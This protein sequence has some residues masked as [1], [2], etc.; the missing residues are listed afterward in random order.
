M[1]DKVWRMTM[2]QFCSVGPTLWDRVSQALPILAKRWQAKKRR[3]KTNPWRQLRESPSYITS[4]PQIKPDP[5]IW[6]V[7]SC[8]WCQ[9]LEPCSSACLH[10]NQVVERTHRRRRWWS[11]YCWRHAYFWPRRQRWCW[12]HCPPSLPS[13]CCLPP[14]PCQAETLSIWTGRKEYFRTLLMIKK[15]QSKGKM[16]QVLHSPGDHGRCRI[17]IGQAQEHGICTANVPIIVIPFYG[18]RRGV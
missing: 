6:R 1:R 5:S 17:G 9:V 12:Q 18:Y 3:I 15:W 10:V 8:V 2:E 11:G 4:S 7:C 16:R 14:S 13:A